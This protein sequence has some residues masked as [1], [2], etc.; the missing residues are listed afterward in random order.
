MTPQERSAVIAES[1]TWLGTPYHHAACVKGAGVDCAYYLKGVFEN[2]R[3][4]APFEV[5]AYPNDWHLHRDEERYLAHVMER[6][7]EVV[8]EP[9]P[10][11]I[12][13]FRFGRCVA[14]GAIVVQWPRVIHSYIGRGVCYSDIS[15]SE[16][17]G[18]LHSIWTL[19][20]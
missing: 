13:L 8:T 7:V 11:D 15:D 14:H 18:R 20:S 6:C 9:Q 4:V 12:A 19:R 17:R 1:V 2:A 16:L 3:L 5:K 10:A